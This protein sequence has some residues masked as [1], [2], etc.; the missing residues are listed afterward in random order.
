[1]PLY[2]GTARPS[3]LDRLIDW[4]LG[5]QHETDLLR[6]LGAVPRLVQ[7]ETIREGVQS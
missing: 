2:L 6:S 7:R 5:R 3:L 4:W 1:M